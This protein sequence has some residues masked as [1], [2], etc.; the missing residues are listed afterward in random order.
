[1]RLALDIRLA[2]LALRIERVEG[3]IELCSVDLR[4]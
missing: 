3:E 4:V 2:G 1:M